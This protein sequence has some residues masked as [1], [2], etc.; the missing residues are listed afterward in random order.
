MSILVGLC[1]GPS[2]GKTTLARALTNEL[3]LKGKNAEHVHE[4]ARQHI[5]QCDRST[6]NNPRDLL[7]QAVI[8]PKQ[9]EWEDAVPE[10]V[11][12]VISDSPILIHSVYTQMM[13]DFND[14]NQKM[15]YLQHYQ[16]LLEHKHRY[17]YIFYLPPGDI[18]FVADGLRKQDAERARNI[19]DRIRSFLVFHGL[20]FHTITGSVEERVQKCVEILLEDVSI[21]SDTGGQEG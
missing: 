5:A 10:I 3:G 14:H 19:G 16:T 15:F 17:D 21:S 13:T 2:S 11:E 7:H 9:M 20:E 1:G 8:L 6:V 4:Y 12:F 18:E